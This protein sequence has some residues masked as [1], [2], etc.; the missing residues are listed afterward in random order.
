MSET[1]IIT[2]IIC[3]TIIIITLINTIDWEIYEKYRE[4]SGLKE[5]QERALNRN[6]EKHND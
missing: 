5:I 2:L 1:I 3:I 4:L 6:K